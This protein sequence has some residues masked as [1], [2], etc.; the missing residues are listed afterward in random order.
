MMNNYSLFFSVEKRE[1][2][3]KESRKDGLRKM[4]YFKG[5]CEKSFMPSEIYMI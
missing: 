4:I 3:R 1:S 2:E 5:E